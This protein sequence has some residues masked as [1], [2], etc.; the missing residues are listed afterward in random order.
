V[1]AI[2]I[3]DQLFRSNLQPWVFVYLDGLR[4]NLMMMRITVE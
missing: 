2:Y 1:K 3:A 4:V